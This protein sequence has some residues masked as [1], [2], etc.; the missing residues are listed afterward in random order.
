MEMSKKRC[1]SCYHWQGLGYC[2]IEDEPHEDCNQFVATKDLDFYFSCG[3]ASLTSRAKSTE[4]SEAKPAQD[5]SAEED[6][7]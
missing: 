4:V 7:D 1:E 3:R 5:N 2:A 6:K